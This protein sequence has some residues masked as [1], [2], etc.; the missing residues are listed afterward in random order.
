MGP[1]TDL[2]TP[3][4]PPVR[5]FTAVTSTSPDLPFRIEGQRRSTKQPWVLDLVALG[6]PPAKVLD[7]FNQAITVDTHGRKTYDRVSVLSYIRGCL[8]P[9]SEPAWD[10]LMEDKDR[11]IG[12]PQL[13]D[14]AVWLVQATTGRPTGT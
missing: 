3:P 2:P 4:P 12:L 14:V 8:A 9:E 10:A 11:L 6:E 13:A 5:V 1:M 7:D